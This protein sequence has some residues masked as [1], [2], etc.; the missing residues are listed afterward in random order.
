L[1]DGDGVG[2]GQISSGR[3]SKETCNWKVKEDLHSERGTKFRRLMIDRM[4]F[5]RNNQ[6]AFEVQRGSVWMSEVD[7]R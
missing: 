1:E 3:S 7:Q 4:N 2:I 5:F 6:K